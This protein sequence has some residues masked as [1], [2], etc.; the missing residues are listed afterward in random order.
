MKYRLL[1]CYTLDI[2]LRTWKTSIFFFKAT[3][4]GFRCTMMKICQ[5][6]CFH[7]M[8]RPLLGHGIHWIPDTPTDAVH[9]GL[10]SQILQSPAKGLNCSS[11]STINVKCRM[12]GS[13]PPLYSAIQMATSHMKADYF[14]FEE[15][16]RNCLVQCLGH[17]LV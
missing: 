14:S 10:P 17:N 7:Q 1:G 16:I 15:G 9:G 8:I 12:S 5:Q 2:N 11:V 3:V 4:A 13:T 6:N